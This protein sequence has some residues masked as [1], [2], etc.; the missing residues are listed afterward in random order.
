MRRYTLVV[1]DFIRSVN[2]IRRAIRE[3]PLRVRRVMWYGTENGAKPFPPC[4]P[5]RSVAES[6]SELCEDRI[7]LC[8]IRDLRKTK[9]QT[10]IVDPDTPCRPSGSTPLRSAQDDTEG[11]VLQNCI[12]KTA[13][14]SRMLFCS[15]YILFARTVFSYSSISL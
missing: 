3:S 15:F 4:H 11:G 12:Q 7:V 6:K 14:E 1:Q 13:F 10:S 8:T 2:F 5:E 9:W